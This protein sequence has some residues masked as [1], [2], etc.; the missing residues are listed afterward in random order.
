MNDVEI[1]ATRG[2]VSERPEAATNKLVRLWQRDSSVS[3]IKEIR[4]SLCPTL[5]FF[6]S[7]SPL[8]NAFWTSSVLLGAESLGRASRILM[9]NWKAFCALFRSDG[10][11]DKNGSTT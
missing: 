6:L 8:S 4:R 10:I 7:D 2:G 5:N 3:L 1:I 9:E 11:D